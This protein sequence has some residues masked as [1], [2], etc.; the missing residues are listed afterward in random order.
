MTITD[1]PPILTKEECQELVTRIGQYTRG[2]GDT[3]III[4]SAWNRE[5]RWARNHVTVSGD[6]RVPYIKVVRTIKDAH[7]EALTN[8]TDPVS[9]ESV[10]RCAERSASILP[11]HLP[12]DFN[13]GNPLFDYSTSTVW[14]AAT[15]TSTVESRGALARLL[16]EEAEQ[17]SMLS[18]GYLEMRAT[19]FAS[20]SVQTEKYAGMSAQPQSTTVQGLAARMHYVQFTQSQCS[21]TV[22]HPKGTG[23][24]W[25]GL[26]SYDWTTI[27]APALA[28]RA[29]DKCLRSLNAVRIEPGRYTVVL[30]PQAVANLVELLFVGG[31]SGSLFSREMAEGGGGPF[32]AGY[33]QNL[34]LLR[35]K[36]GLQVVDQR[37]TLAHDPTDPFLG[38]PPSLGLQPVVWIKDGVLQTLNFD[39]RYSVSALNSSNPAGFRQSFRLSGGTT[40]IDD[41]I[42]ST[43]RG[44]L[45]SRFSNLRVLDEASVLA[46]GVTRDG[47]W[48]IENGKISKA[49]N[50]MRITESPLFVLNQI[51]HLG[52]PVP[53]FRPDKSPLSAQLQPAVVPPI[54][55]RDFSFTATIDAV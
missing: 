34:G 24:G 52:V 45:V 36:L 39:R 15:N 14:S 28:Q 30:E 44:L 31:G 22:R 4:H 25:A 46:T 1:T 53:V 26:S 3:S 21:M 51:E 10:V 11:N 35:S 32:V 17:R 20:V 27:D 2:G 42:A 6:R 54:T 38:V 48:L 55:A 23:S 50:N 49:V 12:D 5:L 29:L 9:L 41:M 19:A 37:L 40:T 33:D 7:G 47:L 16:T 8:Q 13:P 43:K 18:A